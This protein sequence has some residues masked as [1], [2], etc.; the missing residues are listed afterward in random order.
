MAFST[1]SLAFCSATFML[2]KVTPL[3]QYVRHHCVRDRIHFRGIYFIRYVKVDGMNLDKRRQSN[4][5]GCE[6]YLGFFS[7]TMYVLYSVVLKVGP[8]R[9]GHRITHPR[10]RLFYRVP[11]TSSR[12]DLAMK[13]RRNIILQRL[14]VAESIQVCTAFSLR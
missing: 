9:P 8:W 3:A 4:F 13:T 6:Q 5:M 10:A 2:S 11:G 1:N 7:C 14:V 12:M